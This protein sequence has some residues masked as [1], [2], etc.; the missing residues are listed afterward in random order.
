MTTDKN[1]QFAR[2][3]FVL[4]CFFSFSTISISGQ[5]IV[6]RIDSLMNSYSRNGVFSGAVLAAKKGNIIYKKAFGLA[7][8]DW[9]I[10]NTPDTKFKI[11]SLSKPFTALLVLQLAEAGKLN[12]NATISDYILDYKGKFGDSITID[13]LLTHTS[14]I[15]S[16]LD[17]AEESIQEKLYHDLRD[18]ARYSESADL[19]FKPGTGFRYSNL[20]YNILALIVEKVT[21]K[22]FEEVMKQNIFDRAGLY[23]T[24][25]FQNERIESKLAKGY[26]Y[27]LLTG[28][29]NAAYYDGSFAVG[30][31]GLIS[32]VEDLFLF[33]KA[34]YSDI[35]ISEDYI[36][37]IFTPYSNGHYGYG[38]F[39]NF[40]KVNSNGDSILVA[41]HS[42]H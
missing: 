8:N 1:L 35:L 28:L 15:I 9:N 37:K 5:N 20:A 11:A 13:Q 33:D 39:V 27:K 21:G 29:Q 16:N 36:T 32:T 34:L 26:E 4:T 2:T 12:L 7:D 42:E 25:Q 17:P 3:A 19:C 6:D 31:G 24:C 41:D 23:N 10:P 22:R 14:G 40:R 18:M 38:W 30:P